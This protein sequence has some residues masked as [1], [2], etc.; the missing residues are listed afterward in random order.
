M[1]AV[2]HTGNCTRRA[3]AVGAG[4]CMPSGWL[5]FPEAR[6]RSSQWAGN[7]TTLCACRNRQVCINTLH[8]LSHCVPS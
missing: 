8:R 4:S 2:W 5:R 6:G 3:E 1:G 7:N